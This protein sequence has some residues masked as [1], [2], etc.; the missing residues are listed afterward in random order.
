MSG[1][2]AKFLEEQGIIAQYT[3][4]GTPQQNDVVERRNKRLIDMVRSMIT[5]SNLPL[6]LWNEALKTVVYIL[7]RVPSKVIPKTPFEIWNGGKPS[8]RHIH[9]WGYPVE[10]RVYN[11]HIKKLDPRAISGYFISYPVNSKGYR[12]YCLSDTQRI[13]E[14]RNAKF[15]EDHKVNGVNFLE[16][17]IFRK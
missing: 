10:V 7:N 8:L 13:I 17:L 3:I 2:F 11:H 15:L 5:N 16:I 4:S 12:F 9:I 6:N 1:P 14:D